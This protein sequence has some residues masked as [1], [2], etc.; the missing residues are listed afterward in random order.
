MNRAVVRVQETGWND[1]IGAYASV[2]ETLYWIDVVD[3]QLRCKYKSHYEETLA[4]KTEGVARMMSGLLFARNRITHEVD[5]I[6]YLIATAKGPAGFAANWTWQ[7]L[8]PRPGDR[9][10][11]RHGDYE[12][13]VAGRDVVVTLLAITVFLGQAR[14]MMWQN[15]CRTKSP[16]ESADE[17]GGD[18]P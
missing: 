12:S 15:Y 2:A 17:Q 14:N 11:D 7:S 8:P 3:E 18:E 9:Q 4:E 16:T 1:P 13:A 10:G 5:Q 6:G